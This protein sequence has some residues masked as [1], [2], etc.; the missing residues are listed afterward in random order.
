[1]RPSI[2]LA[3]VIFGLSCGQ[4]HAQDRTRSI[5]TIY[6]T[7]QQDRIKQ[8]SGFVI[9]PGVL[10]TAYHVIQG[11]QSVRIIIST[12]QSLSDI[13]IRNYDAANDLAL[14]E[15][16]PQSTVPALPLQDRIPGTDEELLIAGTPAGMRN[17]TYVVKLAQPHLVPL[18]AFNDT[19]G[20]P[21][22]DSPPSTNV[23]QIAHSIYRGM[24]GGPVLT[25]N[26]F[27]VGVSSGSFNEGGSYGWAIPAPMLIALL[28]RPSMSVDP[29][30]ISEWPPVP[31]LSGALRS[32]EYFVRRDTDTLARIDNFTANSSRLDA[33][34]RRI[35]ANVMS[36]R[37]PLH[38]VLSWFRV[39]LA[40]T[41][42]MTIA[43][44]EELIDTQ[45]LWFSKN[46]DH[47]RQMRSDLAARQSLDRQLRQAI[48]TLANSVKTR[49]LAAS[50]V[51]ELNGAIR[52]VTVRY[53]RVATS[54]YEEIIGADVAGLLKCLDVITGRSQVHFSTFAEA[55][56]FRENL[57][58]CAGELDFYVEFY[59]WISDEHFFYEQAASLLRH[60]KGVAAYVPE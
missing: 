45:I 13:K 33:I 26:G 40:N 29:R 36:Y 28:N 2:V 23:L 14:I 3:L 51:D 4:G 34:N 41:S 17:Q 18:Q 21:L 9:A 16:V 47:Y 58:K 19:R 53:S 48:S 39:G 8:G 20:H 10:A 37:I 43:D 38:E 50:S 42:N 55:A 35:D 30:Q 49:N 5:V 60:Y 54:T 25:G 46:M 56:V 57:Q 59:K 1:M 6:T 52:N 24:S 22:F 31:L 7:T 11:A 12:G 15:F 44:F 27:A 32:T